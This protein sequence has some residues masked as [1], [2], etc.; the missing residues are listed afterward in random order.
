MTA[1]ILAQIRAWPATSSDDLASVVRETLEMCAG[2]FDPAV[3]TLVWEQR[4]EPGGAIATLDAEGFRIAELDEY[5]PDH[6]AP[7]VPFVSGT[8][9]AEL[10]DGVLFIGSPS[11]G[12]SAA[13]DGAELIAALLGYRMDTA[14]RSHALRLEVAVAERERVARDLHDGL[15]QSFTGVVLQ[16]ETI[17]ALIGTNPA[18][19]ARLVTKVQSSIMADQREL[20][21]YVESLRPRRR[22][23]HPFDFVARL[24]DLRLRFEDEWDLRITLDHEAVAPQVGLALGIETFRIIQEAITNSARHGGAKR[25]DV[26]LRTEHGLLF[27][28][29]SDDGMGL[30]LGGRL[31]LDEMRAKG[32]GPA[33][34]GERVTALNGQL[35]AT[36]SDHGLKLE[37]AVPLGWSGA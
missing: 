8:V 32:I 22:T 35:T 37:I 21:S 33:S 14:L 1:E 5:D 17:H 7:P 24:R 30:A 6:S 36:S 2:V 15:L 12:G 11:R 18:E 28:E 13:R 10:F 20:R 19:A 16:L 3:T 31:T 34:L 25:V 27:I 4:E 29:V 9:S 26:R 23:E